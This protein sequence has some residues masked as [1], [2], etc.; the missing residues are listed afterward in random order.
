MDYNQSYVVT[1]SEYSKI[2]QQE[3]LA[4]EIAKIIR[5][6]KRKKREDKKAQWVVDS[7]ILV[8]TQK[9]LNKRAKAML[10]AN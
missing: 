8:E 7:F 4:K 10:N 1:S 3:T 5:H 9:L 2:L 6:Q